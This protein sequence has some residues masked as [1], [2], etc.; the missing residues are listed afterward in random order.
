MACNREGLWL[1]L[2]ETVGLF[3]LKSG[4]V[5]QAG[6]GTGTSSHLPAGAHSHI[7]G[8]WAD[9]KMTLTLSNLTGSYTVPSSDRNLIGLWCL[10]KCVTS[11]SSIKS[12]ADTE[13]TPRKSRLVVVVGGGDGELRRDTDNLSLQRDRVDRFSSG[14]LV[15]KTNNSP[16]WGQSELRVT[17]VYYL[18]HSVLNKIL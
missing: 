10:N 3:D 18:Q 12:Y 17:T 2:L 8:R 13:L 6:L 4:Q 1:S 14:K 15:R 5:D 16:C 9:S 7:L 11:L